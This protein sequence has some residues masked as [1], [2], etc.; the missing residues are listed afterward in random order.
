MS[1][2]VLILF[3]LT[4][5][6]SAAAFAD[7]GAVQGVGGAIR[8]MK[9]HPSVLMETMAVAIQVNP[10]REAR[11]DC[12]FVFRNTGPATTV[13]MGFPESAQGYGT[14][15]R[16]PRGFTSFATWV[17]GRRVQ[18]K[19]EGFKAEREIGLWSRWRVKAVRFATGQTRRVRVQYTAPLG[20]VSDGSRFFNY[21]IGTGGSWKGPIGYARLRVYPQYQP[22]KWKL[23]ADERHRALTE[24]PFT[25]TAAALDPAPH[26]SLRVAF[27]PVR[28]TRSAS[29]LQYPVERVLGPAEAERAVQ[30]VERA[31]PKWFPP[32]S[33]Q[34]SQEALDYRDRHDLPAPWLAVGDFNGDGSKDVAVYLLRGG[35]IALA[36]LHGKAK[37]GFEVH[38]LIRPP[39]TREKHRVVSNLETVLQTRP[40]A[41]VAYWK[42][43][44]TTPKSGRLDLKHDGIEVIG[45]G[46]ASSLYY[47][48][49]VAG[50]YAEVVTA[51]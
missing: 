2:T 6:V 11:V 4:L 31:A 7:D 13:R 36:V 45:L 17:D 1:R 47:W 9:E 10:E 29:A 21:R 5:L 19:I 34:Y 14:D 39:V 33:S 23:G 44:E 15:V 20:Q 12:H 51:D 16:H 3:V 28:A 24:S 43:G 37:A 41:L 22:H 27:D 26:E 42:E 25:W 8:A 35:D 38:W 48:D 46:K 40:P 49:S 18:A 32:D 50:R 30:A